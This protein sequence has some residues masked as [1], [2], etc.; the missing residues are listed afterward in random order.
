MMRGIN[1]D[2]KKTAINTGFCQLESISMIQMQDYRM[3]LETSTRES[4]CGDKSEVAEM[5]L[6]NT[7]NHFRKSIKKADQNDLPFSKTLKT[8]KTNN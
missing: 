4:E 8:K 1:H 5:Y 2:G 3:N 6:N 7:G